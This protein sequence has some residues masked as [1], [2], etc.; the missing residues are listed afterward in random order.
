MR[1]KTA[2][3]GYGSQWQMASKAYLATHKR[4]K[5]QGP[6]CTERATC[7]DHIVPHKGDMKLFWNRENWQA[8]CASC[9]STKTASE[10][11]GFGN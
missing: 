2:E 3:R 4:C 7:V 1:A 6:S 10:E 8:A 5:I 9:H 11:G